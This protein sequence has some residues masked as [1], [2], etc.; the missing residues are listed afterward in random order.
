[1]LGNHEAARREFGRVA[2]IDPANETARQLATGERP[3]QPLRQTP[4]TPGAAAK[5]APATN[6]PLAPPQERTGNGPSVD[7]G[8]PATLG[9]TDNAGDKSP[10]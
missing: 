10:K 5:M 2:A 7:L 3:P 4:G 9:R 1:M 6:G 8:Q